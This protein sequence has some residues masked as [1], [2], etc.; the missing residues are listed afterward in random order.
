MPHL[1]NLEHACQETEVFAEEAA[2][3]LPPSATVWLAT[4][5]TVNLPS[6]PDGFQLTQHPKSP[7]VAAGCLVKSH[8]VVP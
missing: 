4:L 1:S 6:P 2:A 5:A 3:K 7:G 8:F